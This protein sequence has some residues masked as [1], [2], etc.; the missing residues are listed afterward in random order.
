MTY[1][2]FLKF[3]VFPTKIS[4]SGDYVG[5]KSKYPNGQLLFIQLLALIVYFFFVEIMNVLRLIVSMVSTMN[6]RED[7]T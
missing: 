2:P 1:L 4:I 6:V 5:T 7:S 3:G